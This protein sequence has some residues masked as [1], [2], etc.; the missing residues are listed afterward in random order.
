MGSPDVF[1]DGL[2]KSLIAGVVLSLELAVSSALSL[3]RVQLIEVDA[4]LQWVADLVLFSETAEDH[5][6]TL[7]RRILSSL[8]VLN[9]RIVAEKALLD[10]PVVVYRVDDGVHRTLPLASDDFRLLLVGIRLKLLSFG[11]FEVLL[12][13]HLEQLRTVVAVHLLLFSW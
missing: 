12:K 10:D 9:R 1:D 4:S 5:I 8:V 2:D 13:S 7:L 6:E 3:K 11:T